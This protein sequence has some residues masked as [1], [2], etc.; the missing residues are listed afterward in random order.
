[1]ANDK[2]CVNEL[3]LVTA[4]TLIHK[5]PAILCGVCLAGD[6]GSADC[7]LY[8]GENTN[9]KEKIHL[10]VLTGT[11][12]NWEPHCHV[13]INDGIYVVVSDNKAHVMVTYRGLERHE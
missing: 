6:G 3:I 2:E 8:D 4:N 1:M 10:E 12:F 11:T 7:Q 5:G 9:G 13:R